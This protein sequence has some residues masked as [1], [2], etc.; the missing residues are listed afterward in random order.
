MTAPLIGITAD[1]EDSGG[2]SKFPWYALRVN[3]CSAVHAAGGVPIILP[4]ELSLIDH[5]ADLIDGLI[6]SGGAFDVPPSL[7][8][9]ETVHETVVL[10][11]GRTD[12]ELGL[13]QRFLDA[14]RPVFGICGG[15]QLLAVALGG[16]L[17]QHIPDEVENALAHEQPN[18]RDEAGH[19]VTI[20]PGT[21]MH[22]IVGVD[23]LAVN[24][25]HHQ[26]VKALPDN[27][28]IDA[29][30]SDGVIEGIEDPS[31]RWCIGVQWH[32]EFHISEGDR[33]LYDSFIQACR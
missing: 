22:E 7:F 27:I 31:K 19:D 8:G 18:P 26:A 16:S 30:S 25:A 15:Q 3:Y 9:D 12:F 1:R 5:Y 28:V 24:S 17:I 20:T 29:V 10:K 33:R 4:N 13:T 23:S 11:A 6:V 14:D 21:R 2:Y 32:P